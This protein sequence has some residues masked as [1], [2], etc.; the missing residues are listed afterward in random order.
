MVQEPTKV[1]PLLLELWEELLGLTFD[2]E[3]SPIAGH[4]GGVEGV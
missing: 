2:L 4:F 1:F 3:E